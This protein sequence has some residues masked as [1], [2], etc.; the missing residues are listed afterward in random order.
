MFGA[1]GIAIDSSPAKVRASCEGS[2]KRLGVDC[3]DLYYQHR[4]DPKVPIEETVKAM[5]ELVKE[6]MIKYLGLSEC[7]ADEI[8]RAH[9]IHPITAYQVEYSPWFL[10]IETDGRLD[11]CRELG[12]AIV[13]YSP[14]GRGFLTGTI[15]SIDDLAADDWRRTNPKFKAGAFEKNFELVKQMEKLAA[16]KGCT[17]AQLGLAWCLA[18]GP[19]IIP[20]PGIIS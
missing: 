12:I 6:G 2:L 11:T 20:I 17:T 10:N 15:K 9:K 1:D 3:I 13:A 18:Q 16:K 5:A 4:P 19:D 8:R 14:L 7:S